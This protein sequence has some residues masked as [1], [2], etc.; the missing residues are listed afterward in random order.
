MS[1]NAENFPRG[2]S[3][4]VS[5]ISGVEKLCKR[6]GEGGEYQE[7]ASKI[8]C[9]RVPKKVVGEHIKVS[10]FLDIEKFCV[11]E[12]HVTFFDFRSIFFVSQCR[13]FF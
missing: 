10:L 4:S 5:L 6:V 9:L 2:E 8:F 12:V 7:F 3:F 11:S 1:H 13:K